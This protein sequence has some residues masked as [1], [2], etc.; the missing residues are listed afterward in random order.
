MR[1]DP[2]TLHTLCI[3][4][5]PFS[6]V[7]SGCHCRA[8]DGFYH[9]WHW[10]LENLWMLCWI[11]CSVKV[12]K[13]S[14]N[15]LRGYTR[16]MLWSPHRTRTYACASVCGPFYVWEIWHARNANV[17]SLTDTS[18]AHSWIISSWPTLTVKHIFIFIQLIYIFTIFPLPKTFSFWSQDFFFFPS[19]LRSP[20]LT[21][22]W[23]SARNIWGRPVCQFFFPCKFFLL[24]N[25]Y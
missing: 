12:H 5:V 6:R 14:L 17:Q 19:K 24:E 9:S 11:S 8:A 10:V 4:K 23:C 2:H 16:L 7:S 18:N 1:S 21:M 15:G 20:A 13:W 3:Y 25:I 22:V